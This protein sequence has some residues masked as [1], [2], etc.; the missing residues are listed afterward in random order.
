MKHLVLAGL[1]AALMSA[2]TLMPHYQ[3]PASPVPNRWPADAQNP[4][5]QRS[6]S[7][8]SQNPD[9]STG[10]HASQMSA[11]APQTFD[12]PSPVSADKIGWRDFF[13]DSRLQ[14]LIAIAL[15]NNRNLR[16]AVLNVS[17]SEAQFR[18]QRGALFPSISASGAET[19]E[20][21]PSNGALSLGSL[22]GSSS[23]APLLPT[24]SSASIFRYFNAGVGFT[25]YE[26]DLFGRQRSLTTEAFEQYLAQRETRRGTQIGLI[27]EVATDY[28]TV[29]ADQALV[30]V[31]EETLSNETES[32]EII[33][34]MYEHETT[35]LLALRQAESAVD[36]ARSSLPQYQ[37]QLAQDTH[38]LTL[39]L[40]EE[41]PP[42]LLPMGDIDAEVTLAG[43]PAGLPS[44]L[45]THRP[46]I[47]S[48]EHSLR[49]ANA[50]IGAAR[51]AFL[52][53]IELTGSGGTASTKLQNLFS[54]GTGTWSFAPSINLPI[55]TGGRNRANLDLAHVEKRIE[56]AQYELTIQTA[57][58]EVSD[59]L[60]ARGSYLDQRRAQRELVAADADAYRLAQMRFRSGVDNYLATL[61]AQR[62]LYAAQQQLV[63]IRQAQLANEVTLYKTLGGG[64]LQSTPVAADR[65]GR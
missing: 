17:A 21:L 40:G 49:A 19:V 12:G 27:G 20:K 53:S 42:D 15:E 6:A 22:G 62:S 61:D 9:A 29:L 32:Y 25:N 3:Q 36:E 39:V 28:I 33:K 2:C 37:R 46:D 10:A 31:T 54:K 63:V 55:F 56:I 51:A 1:C 43:I 26:L 34:A 13:L 59:A 47:L 38:A 44:D 65:D 64:W 4:Q 5:A 14:R 35:T 57:F 16:I 52:P 48:A 7:L 45:L 50:D 23:G 58:R 41:P 18:I 60:S 8:S 24:G 11:S 30:K